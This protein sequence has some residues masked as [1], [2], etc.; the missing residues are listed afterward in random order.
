MV[1]AVDVSVKSRG[2]LGGIYGATEDLPREDYW[3]MTLWFCGFRPPVTRIR[4][5]NGISRAFEQ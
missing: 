2:H 1:I 5:R 3:C 4:I